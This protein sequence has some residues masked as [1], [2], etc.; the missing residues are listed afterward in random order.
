MSN[1]SKR[2]TYKDFDGNI[3]EIET[4]DQNIGISDLSK[5]GILKEEKPYACESFP[6]GGALAGLYRRLDERDAGLRDSICSPL[7]KK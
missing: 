1:Y 5:M 3:R 4:T 7:K 6:F 2:Y